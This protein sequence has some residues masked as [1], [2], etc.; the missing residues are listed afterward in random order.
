M[1]KPDSSQPRRRKTWRRVRR[2]FIILLVIIGCLLLI[3]QI[4][5]L[6][7][8]PRN[9][10]V[11]QLQ[12]RLGLRVQMDDLSIGW[13]GR[14]TIE[15][16][17]ISLPLGDQPLVVAPRIELQHTSLPVL[18][19]TQSFTLKNAELREPIFRTTQN[20]FGRWNVEDLIAQLTAGSA[21]STGT[22]T[23]QKPITLPRVAV[24]DATIHVIDQSGHE[25][26]LHPIDL[27]GTPQ[28]PAAYTFD[29]AVADKRLTATGQIVTA[30]Q[31]QHDIRITAN[32]LEPIA[33]QLISQWPEDVS[34][35]ARWHGRVVRGRLVGELQ[36]AG[37]TLDL[38][39]MQP[40]QL[41]GPVQI[42]QEGSSFAIDPRGLVVN[43]A[44]LDQPA[45]TVAQGEVRI[46]SNLTITD[47]ELLTSGGVA[48]INGS[49]DFSGKAIAATARWRDIEFPRQV[50]QA[51]TISLK[52]DEAF[53]SEPRFVIN[54]DSEGVTPDGTWK[55]LL[56]INAQGTSWKDLVA[57]IKLPRVSW[58]SGS[59]VFFAEDLAA[60]VLFQQN[61]LS[62]DSLSLRDTGRVTGEGAYDFNS[63]A[64]WIYVD[65]ERAPLAPLY[66]L[67][68]EFDINAWGD[69]NLI[70]L[71][72][73]YARAEN[74]VIE[75]RGWYTEEWANPFAL[76][77]NVYEPNIDNDSADN[78]L[79]LQGSIHSYAFINGKLD[80]AVSLDLK[81][82][83]S[84]RDLIIADRPVGD[85][86]VELLGAVDGQR[87]QF[88]TTDMDLFGGQWRFAG[89]FDTSERVD[90]AIVNVEVQRMPLAELAKTARL[91][92]NVEGTFNGKWQLARDIGSGRFTIDG[93][94]DARDVVLDDPATSGL[95][96]GSVSGHTY[97]TNSRLTIDQVVAKNGDGSARAS[98][99]VQLD[100]PR[101]PANFKIALA[102]W[103]VDY[104]EQQA[105]AIV[106]G[107]GNFNAT[108][109][110]R[111]AVGKLLLN[112]QLSIADRSA[113]T[114][115]FAAD[116]TPDAIRIR[117]LKADA[118]SGTA[119]GAF[120][121]R[122][123]NPSNSVGNLTFHSIKAEDVVAFV[124]S[125]EGLHGAIDGE[126]LLEP[127]RSNPRALAP[128]KAVVRVTP[129]DADWRGISLGIAN[130]D[131]Y[132]DINRDFTLR[133]AVAGESSIQLAGG[134]LRPWMRLSRHP[135]QRLARQFMFEF[136]DLQLE[137]LTLPLRQIEK[138][139]YGKLSGSVLLLDNWRDAR[140]TYAEGNIRLTE[141]DLK[142]VPGFDQV[143][144]SNN[145]SNNEPNGRG[146]L[147]FRI[148]DE[149]LELTRM[150]HFERGLEI[151]GLASIQNIFDMPDSPVE[152]TLV[153]SARPLRDID[154]PFLADIDDITNAFQST[155]LTPV[156]IS[157]TVR[158]PIV[159]LGAFTDIGDGMR[160][161]LIGESRD[162]QQ[163]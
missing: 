15:G 42:R 49:S 77:V 1:T 144:S 89:M 114:V 79:P 54:A 143:F 107:E 52:L 70:T 139:V 99:T 140:R 134:V 109:A 127:Q 75:S 146:R 64:W 57:K 23:G 39:G 50:Q 159:R 56:D 4:I 8:I 78:V 162:K 6:T 90:R 30:G 32:D 71:Q 58:Q 97:M 22:S 130:I 24:N 80:P 44:E 93:I 160:K 88:R 67:P 157:G 72:Q 148:D 158:E 40:M 131:V 100:N 20:A 113:G 122:L 69:G 132:L 34:L 98:A 63:H 73:L 106:N 111:K 121:I 125:L 128:L 83:L 96:L 10:V 27:I 126:I 62:F 46:G 55:A 149:R 147:Q 51:G 19:I 136:E 108:L 26:L 102:N 95:A 81:G 105:S 65:A 103:Q 137:Q 119:G 2:I 43:V 156:L 104:P 14:T 123:D 112:S 115:A 138:P 29:L 129:Q 11:G 48:R 41:S 38:V 101:R 9:I 59:R 47:L 68:I 141:S 84:A 35:D 17:S 21:P 86:N 145:V 92:T 37:L 120:E 118:F 94:F 12:S 110:D 142:N 7:D 74:L 5:L 87:L 76:E 155:L 66:G 91:D 33:S 82:F 85:L 150:D 153:P 116:V 16:L 53:S 154:L 25:V 151:T 163:R 133:R 152:A 45:I 3:V 135:D 61:T 117:D 18:A 60:R 124:P 36:L 161:L 13:S 31:L 28:G